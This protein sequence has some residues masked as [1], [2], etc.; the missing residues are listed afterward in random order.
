M[1]TNG[2][3]VRVSKV[4]YDIVN[5]LRNVNRTRTA[6]PMIPLM[7]AFIGYISVQLCLSSSS[8]RIKCVNTRAVELQPIIIA[9]HVM[10]SYVP[11]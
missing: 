4:D 3:D 2:N 11:L 9:N 8:K 6:V 10:F 1:L 7:L 5:C